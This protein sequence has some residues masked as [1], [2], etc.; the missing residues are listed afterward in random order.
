MTLSTQN[1]LETRLVCRTSAAYNLTEKEN[2]I[3]INKLTLDDSELKKQL[4]NRKNSRCLKKLSI[5]EYKGLMV[6]WAS[7]SQWNKIQA[8]HAFTLPAHRRKGFATLAFSMLI[9]NGD[10]IKNQPLAVFSEDSY[11][12]AQSLGIKYIKIF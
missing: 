2:E 8:Y 1:F 6:S 11:K 7:S 10:F 4:I 3:F 5:V 12:I 9:A